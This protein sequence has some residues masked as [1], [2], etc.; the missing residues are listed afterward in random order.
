MPSQVGIGDS[1]ATEVN[2]LRE[3]VDE[4]SRQANKQTNQ[5]LKLTRILAWLT[6]MMTVLVGAQLYLAI[7]K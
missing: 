4:F 3:S 1:A 5:M 6:A 2:R 7:F